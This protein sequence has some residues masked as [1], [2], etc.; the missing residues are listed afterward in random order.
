[1]TGLDTNVLVGKGDFADHLI[2]RAN[3]RLGATHTVTF[4]QEL[5]GHRPFRVL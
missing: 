4:D 1:M 2:G 3:A 5:K